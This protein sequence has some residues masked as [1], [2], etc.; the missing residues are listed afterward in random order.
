MVEVYI[1]SQSLL[2]I[3]QEISPDFTTQNLID[4][5]NLI[6]TD[7]NWALTEGQDYRIAVKTTGLREYTT[8]GA[9][10]VAKF[11]DIRQPS[12]FHS[13]VIELFLRNKAK[14]RKASI[15]KGILDNCSSLVKRSDRYWISRADLVAI[16]ET[17]SNTLKRMLEESKKTQFP[18]LPNIDYEELLD[19][20]GIYF[21][22]E[23]IFKISQIFGQNLT[24]K[25]RREWCEE[26][27][28]VIKPKISEIVDQIKDREENIEK[29]KSAAQKRDLSTCQVTRVRKD[30]ISK[31]RFSVHHLYAQHAYPHIADSIDNLITLDYK[32]HD[33]FHVDYMGGTNQPCTIDDFIRFVHTYYPGNT[34]IITWLTQQKIKLGNPEPIDLA[35]PPHVLYLPA[36]KV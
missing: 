1:T 11:L 33:Q 32:V 18:L 28:M 19:Q 25:D 23:G 24:R 10:T 13:K 30:K 6:D 31:L 26:V 4:L 12:G 34:K 36:S 14:V 8:A 20:G 35:K 17:N 22:L 15:G 2:T 21:S 5:E 3:I 27:G 7:P 9:Y 16:L 29:A